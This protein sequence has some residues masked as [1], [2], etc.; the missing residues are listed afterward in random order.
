MRPCIRRGWVLFYLLRRWLVLPAAGWLGLNLLLAWLALSLPDPE[1]ASIVAA[2]DNVAI[3]LMG[4]LLLGCMWLGAA[5]AVEND[6]RRD[7]GKPPVEKVYRQKVL[8]WPDLVYAELI[9][10][11]LVSAGLLAWSLAVP[12][13][14]EAPADPSVTPNPAKAPWYFVGLQELLVYSDAWYA[15]VVVPT[16]AIFGLAA[17]PYL[18]INRKGS[19]Y[20]SIQPRRFAWLVFHFGFVQMWVLMIFVGALLRGPNWTLYGL[21]EPREPARVE[22]LA[23]LRLSDWFW[24]GL[25]GRGVPQVSAQASTLARAATILWREIA[26]LVLLAAW[27][28]GLPKLLRRT[29]MKRMYLRM[30]GARYWIMMLL[31]L[32]ML[33]LPL[34]MILRWTF[35]LTYIV[36]FPEWS[37][38]L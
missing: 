29:L 16:L 1:F 23:G 11:V 2:P 5:Q 13:P 8:V 31:L 38:S 27:F 4:L 9:C 34:K 6:R 10:A 37:L 28:V 21:Y 19:G 26:G 20:Y 12:A 22:V 7:R 14:L 3:V 17:L 36:S 30:Q 35:G 32:C 25:L 33:I 18:D 24:T 15:G